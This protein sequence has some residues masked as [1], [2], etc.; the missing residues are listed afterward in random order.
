MNQPVDWDE[1][2]ARNLETIYVSPQIVAQRVAIR[3]MLA[4]APGERVLDIG[5]GTGFLLAEMAAEIGPDGHA[6]GID[7]SPFNLDFAHRRC[8]DLPQISLQEG[9]AIAL[10][11]EAASF[12]AA[13]SVQVFEYLA[14]PGRALAEVSR[15]L[16][17]GGRA[18]IVATDWDSL[19]VETSDI[20]RHRR[21]L[22][23][24]HGH[25]VDA[26]LPRHL[27][28]LM[29]AAGLVVELVAAFAIL[30]RRIA[31]SAYVG[32]ILDYTAKTAQRGGVGAEEA[33]G[34]RDE[35]RALDAAGR[36]WFS[37]TRSMFIARGR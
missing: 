20:A 1:D 31:A 27:A 26:H 13:V 8:R 34:W 24:S 9:D 16:A 18:L 30:E 23:A 29:E 12:D 2:A 21:V 5:C 3:T 28:P 19:I 33:T 22:D 25:C 35:Q 15:V 32:Q 7:L 17:P 11:F 37:L 4:L 10:P 14:D 36:F 6:A